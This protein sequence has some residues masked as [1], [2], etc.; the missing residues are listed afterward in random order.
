[1]KPSESQETRGL[2]QRELIL[3]LR[4]DVKA[5]AEDGHRERNR[6]DAELA[7]RPTRAEMGKALAVGLSAAGLIAGT[8][9][10][11]IPH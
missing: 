4:T 3:E 2:S 7:K 1:M 6:I 9:I 8:L 5:L 10:S 11:L